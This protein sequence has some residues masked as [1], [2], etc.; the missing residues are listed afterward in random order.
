MLRGIVLVRTVLCRR[1]QGILRNTRLLFGVECNLVGPSQSR[2]YKKRLRGRFWGGVA[3]IYISIYNCV[4]DNTHVCVYI[5]THTS[6]LPPYI[7]TP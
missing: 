2:K 5:Y 7:V 4:S 3:Y 6:I 1:R